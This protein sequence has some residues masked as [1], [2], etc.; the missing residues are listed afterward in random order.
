MRRE[1]VTRGNIFDDFSMCNE[2]CSL[3]IMITKN[4]NND[5]DSKSLKA[6]SMCIHSSKTCQQRQK[7][8]NDCHFYYTCKKE[9]WNDIDKHHRDKNTYFSWV[10]YRA[11]HVMNRKRIRKIEE[12]KHSWW[13]STNNLL[14]FSVFFSFDNQIDFIHIEKYGFFIILRDMLNYWESK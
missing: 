6:R 8:E 14:P 9:N 7:R 10:F 1:D 13:W 5:D 4:N 12:D 2:I 11:Q 3:T